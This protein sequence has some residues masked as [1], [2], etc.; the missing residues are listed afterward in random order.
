VI[1]VVLDKK[2]TMSL[3]KTVENKSKF[4]VELLVSRYQR[5]PD[6]YSLFVGFN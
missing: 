3:V 1:F 6:K 5:A 2:G 4:Q